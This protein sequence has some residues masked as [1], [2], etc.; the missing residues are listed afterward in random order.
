MKNRT[1][2]TGYYKYNNYY[3]N[4][5]D[6][7]QKNCIYSSKVNPIWDLKHIYLKHLINN[8]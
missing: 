8:Q 2:N 1:E 5:F 6:M 7:D 4:F 3:C